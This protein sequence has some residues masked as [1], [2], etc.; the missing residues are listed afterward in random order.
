MAGTTPYFTLGGW[1]RT[2]NEHSSYKL[3]VICYRTP[4]ENEYGYAHSCIL[5]LKSFSMTL[6]QINK[7]MSLI[8]ISCHKGEN[9]NRDINRVYFYWSVIVR[10]PKLLVFCYYFQVYNNMKFRIHKQ[11]F[12]LVFSDKKHYLMLMSE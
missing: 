1:L 6:N 11:L 12:L 5:E 7:N 8:W 3:Q 10:L 4:D 2:T 9:H